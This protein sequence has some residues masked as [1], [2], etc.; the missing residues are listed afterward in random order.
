M[1]HAVEKTAPGCKP[2]I[3]LQYFWRRDED[4]WPAK[5]TARWK[6]ALELRKRTVQRQRTLVNKGKAVYAPL[7]ASVVVKSASPPHKTKCKAAASTKP[8]TKRVRK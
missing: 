1:V 4:Q 3:S 2:R 6:R 5:E 8:K 7:K